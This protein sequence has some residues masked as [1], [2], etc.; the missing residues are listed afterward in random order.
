MFKDL[1]QN[2]FLEFSILLARIKLQEEEIIKKYITFFFR[3]ESN[4][5]INVPINSP[6]TSNT[7]TTITTTTSKSFKIKKYEL[8]GLFKRCDVYYLK[9]KK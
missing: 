4:Q 1:I 5:S 2:I 3:M 7:T 6:S 8:I 9:I